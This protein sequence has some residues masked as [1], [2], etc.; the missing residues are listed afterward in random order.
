MLRRF[1]V[2]NSTVECLHSGQAVMG[3]VHAASSNVPVATRGQ[4]SLVMDGL[5]FNAR[6][7]DSS[8][9]T[10]AE[11]FLDLYECHGFQGALERING[12]FAVAVYDARTATL[13][14]ARDR[15][16][17]KPL[18]YIHSGDI[19]AF[20]S[21]PRCMLGLPGVSRQVNRQFVALF[22]GSHYRT[23]DNDPGASPFADIAQL[24]GGHM[25]EV[26]QRRT[27]RLSRYWGLSEQP[28]FTASEDE[29]SEE[30]RALLI[31][32][33]RLRFEIANAPAF[34][35]SG[36]M[37]SSSVLASAVRASGQKQD[38]FSTV[39]EDRTYDEAEE[40]CSMLESTVK[41]WHPL[42]VG[43]PDV[44]S[45]IER[46]VCI[47]DEPVATATWLPH[48]LLCEAA[49]SQGFGALFGGLGGDELNAGEYEHFFFHFADLQ[50]VGKLEQL[51]SEVEF[52]VKY[53][54]HPIHQKSRAVV[55]DTLSR[56]V[57]LGTP[58]RCLADR[59]R[60]ERY[61]LAV[62]PEFFDIVEFNPVMDH[63]FSS[64][65][66]N[67][68][69]QDIFRE[70]APCCLRAEDRHASAFGLDHIDPFFDH[71]LV[72]FMFRVPGSLKIRDGVT[73]VL[74]REATRGLLPE[75]T[76]TRIKK[77]GWNAPAHVWFTGA[78]LDHVRDVVGTQSFRER[79]IYNVT[80]VNRIIDEHE[81]IIKTDVVIENHMMFLWQ[82]VNLDLWLRS[83]E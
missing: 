50:H 73:K 83:L 29:L 77:T 5:I 17:V 13:W 8:C 16:G 79:G 59:R 35:L 6:D 71:R 53:H 61:R 72:E 39:Y 51:Q 52:W 76:R 40:I 33:V 27:L 78:T 74:L 80:E 57:D 48:Y 49:V 25:L 18:Y 2:P 12:D 30:Y 4:I 64:Y 62:S 55:D 9:R 54:D 7:F 23:F 11:A 56:L 41:E 45:L 75:V 68:T 47:H 32:A 1:I 82:L 63:P 26:N 70:T 66:R 24:P 46:M 21:Q 60:L 65:L 36:G 20:A 15:F 67:R 38:A 58:G 34:M 81:H 42:K 3:A 37:D 69:Y 14:L 28:E 10:M 19:F 43:T 44:F 22:A 31:D